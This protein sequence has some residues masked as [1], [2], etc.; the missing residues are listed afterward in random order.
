MTK[1]NTFAK[2]TFAKSIKRNKIARGCANS[3]GASKQEFSLRKSVKRI[4]DEITKILDHGYSREDVV[5]I[6]CNTNITN[7]V[8]S[9][10]QISN[11]AIELLPKSGA[12]SE[13]SYS[14]AMA[15]YNDSNRLPDHATRWNSR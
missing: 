4:A 11:I 10:H 8:Q 1:K 13:K 7:E 12:F 5:A 15:S 6:L 9:N 14:H 3:F 2:N